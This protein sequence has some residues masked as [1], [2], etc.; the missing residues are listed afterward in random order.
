LICVRCGYCCHKLSVTIVD[1][2]EKGVSEGNLIFHEGN[3]KKC[4]HL[5]GDKMGNFS[6]RLHNYSW[7]SET[8]CYQHSQIE[9]RNSV[10]RTGE[11][12]RN[13]KIKY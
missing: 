8:P 2:P 7:Y 9:M 11:A 5:I 4:K 13:G 6:C 1:D 12:M 10:C 3:N